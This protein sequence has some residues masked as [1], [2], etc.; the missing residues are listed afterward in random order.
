MKRVRT[1]G[2]MTLLALVVVAGALT[3]FTACRQVAP[4]G[5]AVVE[6]M[7]CCGYEGKLVLRP[8]KGAEDMEHACMF[9]KETR[10]RIAAYS[11][12]GWVTVCSSPSRCSKSICTLCMARIFASSSL[13]G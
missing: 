13:D 11:D 7:E 5:G 8:S 3:L 2:A 4:Q 6:S 10:D 9:C 1:T 12:S